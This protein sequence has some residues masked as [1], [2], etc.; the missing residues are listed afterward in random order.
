MLID[1][2]FPSNGFSIAGGLCMAN[3]QLFIM[4]PTLFRLQERG[5]LVGAG[6]EDSSLTIRSYLSTS[7]A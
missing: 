1:V 3:S 4:A 2:G 5:G 6:V 7:R